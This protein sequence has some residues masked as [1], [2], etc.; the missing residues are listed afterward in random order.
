MLFQDISSDDSN[1]VIL[2]VEKILQHASQLK[3]FPTVRPWSLCELGA[4]EADFEWLLAW[5]REWNYRDADR[6]TNGHQL[7]VTEING[8]EISSFQAVGTL[9]LLFCAECVRREGREDSIWPAVRAD[10]E[11][12][13]RF[14]RCECILWND[15]SAPR[16]RFYRALREAAYFLGVR[17]C[18]RGEKEQEYIGTLRLQYG[19]SFDGAKWL[20]EWLCG[21]KWP[22]PVQQLTRDP[23]LASE[24]FQKLWEAFHALRDGN[25]AQSQWLTQ[26]ANSPWILPQ[27][28]QH[29]AGTAILRRNLRSVENTRVGAQDKTISATEIERLDAQQTSQND[30]FLSEP[31]LGFNAGEAF[32]VVQ[33]QNWW[34]PDDASWLSPDT[35]ILDFYVG[36]QKLGHFRRL[37]RG[38]RIFAPFQATW[39]VPVSASSLIARLFSQNTPVATQKLTFWEASDGFGWWNISSGK[40]C[41]VW[42][43]VPRSHQEY[44]LIVEEGLEFCPAPKFG[45]AMENKHYFCLMPTG[46]NQPRF[47]MRANRFGH[48][49]TKKPQRG[50]K[51]SRFLS[52]KPTR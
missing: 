1:A 52:L 12:K 36:Q 37:E 14:K 8:H 22:R 6:W 20:P 11:G 42:N 23:D 2:A 15:G 18:F 38:G 25:I 28:A 19:F 50:P 49:F 35:D 41:D 9:L 29:L 31:R 45:R 51:I 26:A 40:R 3:F 34:A 27:W 7:F 10:A 30:G 33:A 44:A 13:G 17:H 4:D 43:Q 47:L 24:S 48:P 21:Y 39:E 46:G 32:F 16:G 5:A